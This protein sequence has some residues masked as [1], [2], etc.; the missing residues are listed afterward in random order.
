MSGRRLSMVQRCWLR[1]SLLLEVSCRR[2]RRESDRGIAID[3]KGTAIRRF[4]RSIIMITFHFK[5][6][7]TLWYVVFAGA[8]ASFVGEIVDFF[9]DKK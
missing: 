9:I 7:S 1:C 6:V 8:A 5:H 4:G 2:K 3:L